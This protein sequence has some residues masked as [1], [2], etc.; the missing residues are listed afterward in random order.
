VW[1]R[2][3]QGLKPKFFRARAARLEELAEKFEWVTSAAEAA[4]S[5][6]SLYRSAKKRCATPNQ[7]FSASC[8]ADA[9]IRTYLR[10]SSGH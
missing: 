1:L 6:E 8:K 5:K 3:P 4:T 9:L 2:E 7:S 10:N